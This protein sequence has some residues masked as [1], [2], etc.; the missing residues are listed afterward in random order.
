MDTN[1]HICFFNTTKFWGGGEKIHLDYSLKFKEKGYR[2]FLGVK[3]D[4]PLAIEGK[5][6]GL[7][8]FY[9]ALGNLS[10]LNPIKYYKLIRFFKKEKINTVVISSSHDLKVGSIAAKRAGVQN[11]VYYRALAAPVKNSFFNRLVYG[12]ILT[13]II[14]NSEETRRGMVINM[15]KTVS[16][17][18]IDIVYQGL[19]IGLIDKQEIKSIYKKE[20]V[21]TIGNAGRLTQQ[22]GQEK[23]IEI[24]RALKAKKLTFQILIAGTGDLRDKLDQQII[25]NQLTKEVKL[26]GFVEDVKSFMNDIDIFALTSEWEGFGYVLAEAMVAKKP[27]VAFDITSNPELIKDGENGFLIPFPDNI[28][29]SEKLALLISSS[30]LRKSMGDAGRKIV[31]E[32]F[33][34]D[35][36]IDDFEHSIFS[37][38]TTKKR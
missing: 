21:I 7:A 13:H 15:P 16:V 14:A 11:I 19:D 32:N 20:G 34:L 8:L 17:E 26:L 29:F 23:F 28:K 37:Q 36:I 25:D 27:M 24:A 6:R 4:A 35:K 30:E 10:F 31:E 18:D 12:S 3:K 22:K 5:K 2:V 33:Q 9:I 38:T 1:Q